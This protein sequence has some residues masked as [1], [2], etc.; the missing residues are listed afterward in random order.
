MKKSLLLVLL[1]LISFSMMAQNIAIYD[2]DGNNVS[3]TVITIDISPAPALISHE[4]SVANESNLSASTVG[5]RFEN[6][7]TVG[8]AE[9]FCWNICL[10]PQSCGSNYIREILSPQIIPANSVSPIP[11]A[12][13]FNPS[14][15]SSED[16]LEGTANY[17][18]VLFDEANPNDS[19]FVTVIY[20][21]SATVG[22]DEISE[23]TI[24]NIYPNPAQSTIR[25][26]LNNTISL[27]QF[28]IYSMVG[29]RVKQ[30]NVENAQGLITIDIN[31][32]L[33]GVYFLSEKNSSAT[34]R[35]IVSR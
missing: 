19:V 18:Y 22:V 27:A 3:N 6:E 28:E 20:N 1:G 2:E 9:F 10:P 12:I 5:R 30:I 23:N 14:F 4:F 21:I 7:C 25:F 35:F 13:D 11:L 24:S 8:S 34:R 26:N 32:L 29:K 33:P 31:D 16:G 17:T 15:G